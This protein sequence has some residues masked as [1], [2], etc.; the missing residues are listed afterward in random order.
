MTTMRVV[1][2][3]FFWYRLTRVFPDKFHRA[4]KR[5]C[6]CVYASEKFM[7]QLTNMAEIQ[8]AA[9]YYNFWQIF[10]STA[11]GQVSKNNVSQNMLLILNFLAKSKIT[12]DLHF[13]INDTVIIAWLRKKNQNVLFRCLNF[14][15]KFL[16]YFSA[17]TLLAGWQEGHL[18]CKKL[19][20][21][22]LAWLSAWGKVQT[23]KWPTWCY[24]HSL[25]LAPGNPDFSTGSPR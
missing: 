13:A 16:A 21:G 12:V 17:L 3:C 20:S 11:D 6:V 2:E 19:S 15:G 7:H 14:S 8:L 24:C 1:G 23:C 10:G 9:G 4:V 25:S 5:L 22:V 18:D